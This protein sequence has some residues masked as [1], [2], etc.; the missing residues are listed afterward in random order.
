MLASLKFLECSYAYMLRVGGWNDTD[1]NH[2]YDRN[3]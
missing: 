2:E 3:A 1:A